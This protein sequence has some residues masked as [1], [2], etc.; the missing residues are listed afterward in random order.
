[1]ALE[2]SISYVVEHDAN[3][4]EGPFVFEDRGGNREER[5]QAPVELFDYHGV[6]QPPPSDSYNEKSKA[7]AIWVMHQRVFLL[8]MSGRLS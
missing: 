4:H 1:L 8:D 5:R 6:N 7:A 2:F 3:H